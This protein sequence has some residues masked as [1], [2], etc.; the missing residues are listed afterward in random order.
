M[1]SPRLASQLCLQ[2]SRSQLIFKQAHRVFSTSGHR[3]S[4]HSSDESTVGSG[5]GELPN[6]KWLSELRKRAEKVSRAEK[7]QE[8]SAQLSKI[9]KR[10]DEDWLELLAGR[11]GYLTEP[12]WRGLNKHQIAW[13]DMV[14][15]KLNSRQYFKFRQLICTIF[16]HFYRTA[17]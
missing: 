5:N 11:E 15:P 10:L 16:D 6:P 9:L 3:R 12:R 1:S 14:S 17:W 13:G 8:S 7:S 2:C 4:G